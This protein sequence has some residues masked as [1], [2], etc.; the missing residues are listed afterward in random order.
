MATQDYLINFN[1]INRTGL[2][3]SFLDFRKISDNSSITAPSTITELGRGI[4]KFSYDPDSEDS[5]I[6]WA[7]SDGGT[8]NKTGRINIKNN[9]P[10]YDFVQ[11]SLGMNQEN[12]Y[13]DQTVFDGNNNLTSSRVRIYSDPSSVGTASDVIATYTVTATYS[14]DLLST[15]SVVK[16]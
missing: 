16:Q 5:D 7:V 13:I 1:N 4:Y 6:W 10:I 2:S 8:N 12:Q 3:L 15:F 11:R 14:S 9:V